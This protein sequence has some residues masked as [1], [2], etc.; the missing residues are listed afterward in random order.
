MFLCI[1]FQSK[2]LYNKVTPSGLP[3][4]GQGAYFLIHIRARVEFLLCS[5]N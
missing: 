4:S 2:I 1:D 5:Y 3:P